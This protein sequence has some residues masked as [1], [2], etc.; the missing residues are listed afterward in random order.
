MSFQL[1]GELGDRA[2]KVFLLLVEPNDR[3]II[4]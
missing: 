4:V 2:V 3:T 1:L